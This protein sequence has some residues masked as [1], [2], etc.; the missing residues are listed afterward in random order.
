MSNYTTRVT[1]AKSMQEAMLVLAAGIDEILE[2]LALRYQ[3]TPTDWTAP[4][5]ASSD[6]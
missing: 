2:I 5:D 3:E 1:E 6:A 4:W